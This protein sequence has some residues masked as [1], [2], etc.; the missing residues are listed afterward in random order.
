MRG[1]GNGGT[2]FYFICRGRQGAGCTQPYLRV[3]AMEAAVARYY[4]TVRLSEDFQ[5]RIRA[6][7][8]D[9]LLGD[10]GGVSALKKRLTARL[11]EL[12][13]KEDQYV[14]LVGS[15]GRFKI[16]LRGRAALII[17]R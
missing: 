17:Y 9:A 12:N 5:A 6:E 15:H 3:E 11:A 2:Y 7:L 13:T 16:L 8:D 14:D 10:L 1:R 4:A